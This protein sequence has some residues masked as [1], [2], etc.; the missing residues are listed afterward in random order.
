[1]E[2]K[3]AKHLIIWLSIVATMVFTIVIVGGITRLTDSGLSMVDWK[4]L[5]G[6]IPPLSQ[7]EW[8]QTFGKYQQFPEYKIVNK[9][10]TLEE[11][12]FIF[13]WEYLHRLLGRLIGALFFFPF[14][15][16]LWKQYFNKNLTIKLLVGLALGGSQGLMGWFMVKSGLVNIPDVSHYRLAAHLSLAVV[17]FGYLLWLIF[18]IRSSA[19]EADPEPDSSHPNPRSLTLAILTLLF[20]Q[21]IYGA[22]MAGKHAGH[23]YNTFPTM[24]GE[25]VPTGLLAMKPL[26][27]NFFENNIMIQFIHR[28]LAWIISLA[29]ILYWGLITFK[30]GSSTQRL[31]ARLLVDVLLLQFSLGVLTLLYVVPFSLA[32]AHQ[33]VAVLLFGI[34]IYCCHTSYT[35]AQQPQPELN[36]GI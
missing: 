8:Q 35:M 12:K 21:I 27:I 2:L 17:I 31:G 18:D 26:W 5:M 30:G 14:L 24:N 33:G 15:Y 25:W 36:N 3:K 23:G 4:P 29:I 22:F 16:F 34:A 20:L 19:Q 7:A 28:G 11:F 13:F 1:M 10:M 32:L 9:G 6:A